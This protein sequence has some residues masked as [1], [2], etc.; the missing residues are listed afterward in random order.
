MQKL[1]VN[2]MFCVIFEWKRQLSVYLVHNIREKF[3][4]SFVHHF[5]KM[6]ECRFLDYMIVYMVQEQVPKTF[7]IMNVCF[8]VKSLA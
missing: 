6:K 4:T 2:Q 5:L 8:G 7:V 1:F 3:Y